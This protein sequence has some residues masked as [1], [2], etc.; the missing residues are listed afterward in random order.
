[1]DEAKIYLTCLLL[2]ERK[3]FKPLPVGT[4]HILYNYV[5]VKYDIHDTSFSIPVD[6]IRGLVKYGTTE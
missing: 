2:E 6:T 3:N 4:F 5:M 1:M